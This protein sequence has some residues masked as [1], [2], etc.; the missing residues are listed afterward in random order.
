VLNN[1]VAAATTLGLQWPTDPITL[2]P[3]TELLKLVRLSQ[4]EATKES[5]E[6]E[7]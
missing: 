6:G 1:A 3:S 5:V 4:Q 2:Q 7:A